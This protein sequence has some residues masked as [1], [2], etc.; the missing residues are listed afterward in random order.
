MAEF[1]EDFKPENGDLLYGKLK[2]RVKYFESWN[3]KWEAIDTY[4]IIDGFNNFLHMDRAESYADVQTLRRVLEER[5]QQSNQGPNNPYGKEV[6]PYH[7]AISKSPR[8]AP[9]TVFTAS[10]EKVLG[11]NKSMIKNP[12]DKSSPYMPRPEGEAL[13]GNRARLALKRACK[14]GIAFVATHEEL[15]KSNARIHYA[16]DG[17]DMKTVVDKAEITRV[18]KTQQVTVKPGSVETR[19]VRQDTFV[20][21]TTSELRYI[22]R[23]WAALQ[24]RVLFYVNYQRTAVAPWEGASIDLT[25]CFGTKVAFGAELWESYSQ[26]LGSKPNRRPVDSLF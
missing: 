12:L 20:P 23:H 15:L 4:L 8:Y 14:F 6:R 1:R 26:R 9:E 17:L 24:E 10:H 16:L 7:E 25:D 22:Y 21:I 3:G 18:V 19:P 13:Q 11:G 2:A 5:A